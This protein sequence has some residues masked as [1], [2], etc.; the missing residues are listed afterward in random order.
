MISVNRK[1]LKSVG[2]DVGSSTSHLVISEI[3]LEKDPRSKTEKFEVVERKILYPGQIFFTPLISPS[4]IDMEALIDLLKKEYEKANITIDEIDTGAV[5]VTG[6]TAK[7]ENAEQIIHVLSKEAGKFVSATAGPNFESIIAAKGSGAADRS[8]KLQ[9]VIMNID[10]GG[11]TSNIAVI[12]KGQIVDT[13]CVNVG[14]RLVAS[15][16]GSISRLESSGKLAAEA[17]DLD[18]ELG[19]DISEDQKKMIARKLAEVLIEVVERKTLSPL[20]TDLMM[21]NAL[22]FNGII[23]EITI[24]GGVGEFLYNKAKST[25]F[26]DIGHLLANSIKEVMGEKSLPLAE[27]EQLIRATVIGAG[28]YTLEVSGSTTFLSETHQLPIVN[29]PVLVPHVNRKE[30][31]EEHVGQ[32]INAALRRFDMEEGEEAIALAFHDPVRTVYSQL[33]IFAKGVVSALPKTVEKGLPIIMIFDTDIGNSV[34]SVMARE[35]EVTDNIISI[36]EISVDEGTFVDIGE[37][38]IEGKVVPVSIKS[39]VF[40]KST[41]EAKVTS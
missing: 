20:A 22:T 23:D 4:E 31:N 26:N 1:V 2:I 9:N 40:A 28:Q 33:A 15:D 39:L 32:A 30:L 27:P 3:V 25:H 6:E 14:G 29:L 19:G 36:D 7:K 8:D 24:S 34:G 12:D 13:A 35:T 17:V 11:G 38:I 5:V 18:V 16:N 41:A 37:A 21:T 10:V